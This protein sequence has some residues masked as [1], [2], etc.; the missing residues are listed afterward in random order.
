MA[1]THR[2]HHDGTGKSQRTIP[3]TARARS[4]NYTNLDFFHFTRFLDLEFWSVTSDQT[5]RE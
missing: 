4:E 3:D 5:V 1:R 2:T